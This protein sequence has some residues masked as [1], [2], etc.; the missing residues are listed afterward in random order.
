[1]KIMQT[2]LCLP[3]LFLLLA[4]SPSN[5]YETAMKSAIEKLFAAQTQSEIQDAANTFNRI[6]QKESDKWHPNYY[7]AYAHIMMTPYLENN[8]DKDQQ[9]DLALEL[10]EAGKK[11]SPNNSELTALEGFIHMMRIPIDPSSRGAQYSGMSM[12]A[13]QKALAL[14]PDNPRAQMLLAD[15]QF[16]TARFFGQ[17]NSEGCESLRKALELYESYQPQTPLDPNWGKDWAERNYQ[18]CQ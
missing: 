14:S 17:D 18:Q 6:S 3:I 8:S 15:L 9:L 11:Q 2:I 16:G 1:M 4:S 10:V 13:I 12:S 7:A 5:E